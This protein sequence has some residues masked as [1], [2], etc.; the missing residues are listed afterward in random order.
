MTSKFDT[1]SDPPYQAMELFDTADWEN[2]RSRLAEAVR[3]RFL[4]KNLVTREIKVRYKNSILG[5]F[6]SLLNPLLM[7][8]VYTLLFTKLIPNNAIRIF[9]IFILVGLIPWQFFSNTLIGGTVC[10]TDNAALLRKVYFPRIML[11]TSVLLSNLVNFVLAFLVM[12][13]LLYGYGIGL[14]IYALWVPALL[15]IQMIF[16]QGIIMI[17]GTVQVFYRDVI[18]IL[19]VGLLAWFFLTPVFYPFESLGT[20]TTIMGVTFNPAVVMRWLNPM[21]SIIDGYRTVLWGTM[22]SNGPVNMDPSYLLRTSVT[23]VII[24]IFGYY[25]FNRFEYLFGEKI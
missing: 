15:L 12:V 4:L 17:L 20:S 11:P 24:F 21:A 6:W 10:V 14:T 5:M 13:A 8:V 3:Y 16:M 2:W 19:N 22:G 18:Q 7:M 25:I 1:P 23:A 9:P